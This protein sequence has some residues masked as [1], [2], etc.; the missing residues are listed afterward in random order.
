MLCIFSNLMLSQHSAGLHLMV[1]DWTGATFGI[2]N[3][4]ICVL[5]ILN[6]SLVVCLRKNFNQTGVLW[7]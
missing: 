5:L 3:V 7:S 2:I 1:C 4:W 6:V